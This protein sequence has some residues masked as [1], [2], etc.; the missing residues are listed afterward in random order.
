MLPIVLSMVGVTIVTVGMI[1][2]AAAKMYYSH[3]ALAALVG[4]LL[5]FA[6]MSDN[7]RALAAGAGASAIAGRNARYMG[8]VWTWGAIVIAITYGAELMTPQWKEWWH[9]L[10]AFVL[11][12][13]LCLLFSVFLREDATRGEDPFLLK[14]ARYLATF[15]LVGSLIAMVGLIVD[16]KMTRFLT[17][18][19]TDWPANNVFFF[20]AMAL[21]IIS[22]LALRSNAQV[23]K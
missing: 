2:T 18:R 21:A 8:L 10:F 9:F 17:P 12:A 13:V 5:A 11:A 6:A 7:R 15:Q 1:L 14:I 19:F 22:Y 3:M 20:G 16:G 23:E 4:L